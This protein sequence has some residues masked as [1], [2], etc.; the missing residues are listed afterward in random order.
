VDASPA[1]RV[2]SQPD[3]VLVNAAGHHLAAMR[4]LE[5]VPNSPRSPFIHTL[6]LP[7]PSA[8]ASN[9]PVWARG[10]Q[11]LIDPVLLTDVRGV[12]VMINEAACTLLGY[13]RVDCV[14]QS[15]ELLIPDETISP[16]AHQAKIRQFVRMGHMSAS[17]IMQ[18]TLLA[19]HKDNTRIPVAVLV[20][21]DQRSV[22]DASA[23]SLQPS[24]L[25]VHTI[26][27]V[28]LRDMRVAKAKELAVQ[29]ASTLWRSVMNAMMDPM[30]VI[31]EKGIVLGM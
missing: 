30:A 31:D 1:K 17:H 20:S 16:V 4:T 5:A 21:H 2:P 24:P 12:I 7:S 23:A 29:R 19:R 22:G 9:L 8:T 3:G 25:S 6:Q 18:G 13:R 28:V 14:G 11:N 15:I 27:S 10:V 26:F